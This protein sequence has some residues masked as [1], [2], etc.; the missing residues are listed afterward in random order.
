ML[1]RHWPGSVLPIAAALL[2]TGCVQG[3]AEAPIRMEVRAL[4]TGACSGNNTNPFDEITSVRVKVTGTDPVTGT[5]GVLVD[6]SLSV[7]GTSLTVPDVPEGNGHKLELFGSGG[8]N[9]WYGAASSVSVEQEKSTT[10]ELL[11]TPIGVSTQLPV[12]TTDFA[13]VRFPA[14]A[15]LGDGRIMVSG[16]FQASSGTELNGPSNKW[17]IINPQ[18]AEVQSGQF[19]A[20][21]QGRG[22]HIAVYLPGSGQVLL[23]GGASKLDV[24]SDGSFPISWSKAGGTGLQDAALFTPPPA[25]SDGCSDAADCWS[26]PSSGLRVARVFA[27]AAVTKDGLAVITGGGEWPLESDKDYQR[28]EVFDPLPK[29]GEA[30]FLNVASFDSFQPRSG[31]S[32]TF[33]KNKDD[34]SYLLVFGGTGGNPVAEVMRQSSR[35]QD[36]VDGNFVEVSIQGDTPPNL[37]FHETTRLSGERFLV[38][39]GVP[40]AVDKL[41]DVD[42]GYAYLLTYSDTDGQ[43]PTITSRNLSDQF[44]SG[45]VFH[46]ALSS[47]FTNVAILGGLGAGAQALESD[48]VVFFDSEAVTL[49]VAPDNATFLARAGQAGL[50]MQSGSMILVGG[51]ANLGDVGGGACGH[52]EIYTPSYVGN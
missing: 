7:S 1:I 43:A 30:Q 35:Q 2:L 46:S 19:H 4:G 41:P 51:E 27:R 10:V 39:G 48:K 8:V 9:T 3:P 28:T 5:V 37:F 16:G 22:A 11:L 32:L 21:F 13:N 20:N 47:D 36:G 34:L 24:V 25:G 31:H 26:L 6:R 44:T 12:P 17:F 23:A 33:I 50:D 52:I 42:Q 40:H 45:R 49:A 29:G 15:K 18:T 38:T 14:V